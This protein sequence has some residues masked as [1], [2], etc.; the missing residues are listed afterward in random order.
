MPARMGAN[1]SDLSLGWVDDVQHTYMLLLFTLATEIL[2]LK[3][4]FKFDRS[5]CHVW[6]E[7]AENFGVLGQPTSNKRYYLAYFFLLSDILSVFEY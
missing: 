4:D 1:E 3:I 2:S 7:I 6:L 5:G